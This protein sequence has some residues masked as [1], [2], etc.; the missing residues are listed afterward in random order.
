MAYDAN[1]FK[2][3]YFNFDGSIGKSEF[4]RSFLILF[5]IGLVLALLVP[6]L[7]YPAGIVGLVVLIIRIILA[8]A[9]FSITIRRLRDLGQTGWLSLLL[10]I[11][12]V[13]LILIVY[14]LVADKK[15]I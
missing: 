3:D 6:P 15:I 9:M 8:I 11:P 5:I 2:Q 13:N 7:A 4:Q 12:L 10:L 14:L 1:R